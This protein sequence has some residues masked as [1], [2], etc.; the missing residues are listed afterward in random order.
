M[1]DSS[2]GFYWNPVEVRSRSRVNIPVRITGP[3]GSTE[4][5]TKF[6]KETEERGMLSLKGHRSVGGLR[7][8]LFNAISVEDAMSLRDFMIQFREKELNTST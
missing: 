2:N 4:L 3:D 5:E 8:S 1:I 7:I 6:L